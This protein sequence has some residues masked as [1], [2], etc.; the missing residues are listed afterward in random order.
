MASLPKPLRLPS[1]I[2]ATSAEAPLVMCTT[3]PPAKSSVPR[4]RSQPPVPHTQWA[5]GS[6]TKVAHSRVNSTNALK[7]LRSAKAPVMSAGVMTANII[8]KAM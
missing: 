2:A 8:W 7:R 4:A 3:V 1:T 6:Y 5:I